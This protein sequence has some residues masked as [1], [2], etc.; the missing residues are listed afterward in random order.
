MVAGVGHDDLL[1]PD[2]LEFG[3]SDGP[4][5]EIGAHTGRHRQPGDVQRRGH[6]APDRAE[7]GMALAGVVEERG[8]NQVRPPRRPGCDVPGGVEAVSL[9]GG[10]LAPE[11][12][13]F[14]VA[15]EC[16]GLGLLTGAERPRPHHVDEATQEV[17]KSARARHCRPSQRLDLQST[18]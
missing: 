16:R 3:G 9:I 1:G 2:L 6:A 10:G 17:E 11:E 8:A 4:V 13:P 14:G 12:V 15:Q 18:Q 7:A 5:V